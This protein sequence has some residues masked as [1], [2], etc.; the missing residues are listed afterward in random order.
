MGIEEE[1]KDSRRL[2][3]LPIDMLLFC[4]GCGT[5][6]I[7]EPNTLLGWTNPPHR[8]H[9]CAKCGYLWRPSDMATNGVDSIKSKGTGD[10][11]P[12][13]TNIA[14][15]GATNN[16]RDRLWYRTLLVALSANTVAMVLAVFNRLRPEMQN[17]SDNHE[18]VLRRQQE[19]DLSTEAL[20]L[21]KEPIYTLPA[22]PG[23]I[24]A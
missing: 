15:V 7:D 16:R 3:Y 23:D 5:Q 2:V 13:P 21:V 9:M 19:E 11:D 8:T 20:A 22:K 4:P 12:T 14:V 6:H 1:D 17:T 24:V 10:M 18:H